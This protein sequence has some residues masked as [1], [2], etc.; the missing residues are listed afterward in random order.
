MNY[1]SLEKI[2][3]TSRDQYEDTYNSRFNAPF[4]KHFDINIRQ[5]N[6]KTQYPAFLCYTEDILWLI[7][8]IGAE[9]ISLFAQ[10]LD[11]PENI[12]AQLTRQTIIEE[13][14]ST[15]DIEGV[16]STRKEIQNAIKQQLEPKGNTRFWSLVNKYVKI[17]DKESISFNT[18]QDIRNFYDEF[19]LEEVVNI[20]PDNKPD[21]IIFRKDSVSIGDGK[22]KHRGLFP[23]EKVIKAMNYALTILNDSHMPLFIRTAIF[24]YFFGYIHPFY[25]G[26]GRMSRFITSY[27]LTK[28]I[29][30]MASLRISVLV[31]KNRSKYYKMFDSTN[32]EINRGD[33]TP[34]VIDFLSLILSTIIDIRKLLTQ[35]MEQLDKFKKILQAKLETLKI[36]DPLTIEIYNFLLQSV[37]F[38][39][40]GLTVTE[41]M[42]HTNKARNTINS[43]LT[44][45]PSS[46]ITKDTTTRPY[47]YKL[48][49]IF[50][51]N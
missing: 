25:D 12:L 51:K 10:T 45:I 17:L 46:H 31:K 1:I 16:H 15:N 38:D 37:L 33:L 29:I 40:V 49:P 5:F 24:H 11:I 13:I 18:S 48:N 20:E 39:N 28:E 44:Q 14:K 43:R 34:F 19:I 7:E 21:G 35:K 8:A 50:L 23:E 4:T 30:P 2:Y 41:I 47:R 36:K 9:S 3:Y 42:S 6:H 32:S 22:D 27:Y 26:N